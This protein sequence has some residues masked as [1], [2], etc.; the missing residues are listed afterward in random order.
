MQTTQYIKHASLAVQKMGVIRQQEVFS[1][2]FV[3]HT[4]SKN[5]YFVQIRYLEHNVVKSQL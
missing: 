5:V 2:I 3:R 1:V 4:G